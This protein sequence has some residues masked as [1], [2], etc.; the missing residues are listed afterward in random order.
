MSNGYILL[1]KPKG[2]TSRQ[3]GWRVAK[4]FGGGKKIKFGHVG[5]LDP[6]ATGLLVIALGEATKMIPYLDRLEV[7]GKGY[8]EVRAD[9]SNLLPPTSYLF[10]E[11]LF[12]VEWG[13]ETD[14]LDITGT[15]IARDN[16]VPDIAG[17]QN[18]CKGLVGEIEQIPP[19][20][21]AIHVDGRRAYELARA[22]KAVDIPPRKVTIYDLRL[23]VEGKRY[24][25][26][27]ADTSNLLPPTSYLFKVCCS[28][29]TYVRSL[30]R[31]I[32]RLAGGYL[33]TVTMI[34]RTKTNG[35]DIENAVALDFLENMYHNSPKSVFEHLRPVDFGLDDIPVQNLSDSDAR[36][37][38]NGGVI[39]TKDDQVG[40]RRLYSHNQ[41]IGIG[42]NDNYVLMPKR[43]IKDNT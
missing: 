22:G 19:A 25:E 3:A 10:K 41:F 29:G 14:T 40:L 21:S 2:L 6:M 33:A 34:H 7:E 13:V 9:T 37:F 15:E 11:Y 8:E 18:A 28:A 12:T 42:M 24:E 35:F 4:M 20:Y 43:V 16:R 17:V 38:K 26:A 31:D 23:E 39:I 27:H 5:T 36:L 32:G 1:N 30:A